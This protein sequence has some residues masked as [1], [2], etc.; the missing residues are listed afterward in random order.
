MPQA[1]TPPLGRAASTA[2]GEAYAEVSD[3]AED[4]SRSL[5]GDPRGRGSR[6]SVSRVR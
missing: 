5:E 4:L 6:L 3:L 2:L 1:R